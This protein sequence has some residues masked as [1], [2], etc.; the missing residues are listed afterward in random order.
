[1]KILCGGFLA[2]LLFAA[3]T[4]GGWYLMT[5]PKDRFGFNTEAPMKQWFIYS[6]HDT[7]KECEDAQNSNTI[8]QVQ[9]GQ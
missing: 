2:V 7:A 6:S 8:S 1:M 3:P 5:P 9:E 4:F